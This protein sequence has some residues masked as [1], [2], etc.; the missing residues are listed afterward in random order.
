ML[1]FALDDRDGVIYV[2]Y[3]WLSVDEDISFCVEPFSK[4]V[5]DEQVY[6]HLS[7]LFVEEGV[8]WIGVE[9]ITEAFINEALVMLLWFSF[10]SLPVKCLQVTL[11]KRI[12]VFFKLTTEDQLQELSE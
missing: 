3:W 8:T 10:V 5:N 4:L 11:G 2:L 7:V 6:I 9:D 1:V 12:W